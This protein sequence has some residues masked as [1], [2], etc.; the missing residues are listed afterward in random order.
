MSEKTPQTVFHIVDDLVNVCS[1]IDQHYQDHVLHY[2]MEEVPAEMLEIKNATAILA[3]NLVKLKQYGE[4]INGTSNVI[5]I[6]KVARNFAA[7]RY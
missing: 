3:R 2:D 4:A 7:S 6:R 1:E 5:G